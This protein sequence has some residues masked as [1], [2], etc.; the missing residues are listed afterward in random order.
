MEQTFY[1]IVA[2]VIQG[3]GLY[4]ANKSNMKDVV[5]DAERITRIEENQKHVQADINWIR[6]KLEGNPP[7]EIQNQ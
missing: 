7:S 2:I 5:K 1:V 4:I 6:A 3:I